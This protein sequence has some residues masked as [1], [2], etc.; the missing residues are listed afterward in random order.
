MKGRAEDIRPALATPLKLRWSAQQ[1]QRP[2][3]PW[4][5]DFEPLPREPQ[6]FDLLPR[7]R[8]PQPLDLEPLLPHLG[9]LGLPQPPAP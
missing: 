7:P 2:F 6:L 4:L 9:V 5:F 1:P 8:E 3:E